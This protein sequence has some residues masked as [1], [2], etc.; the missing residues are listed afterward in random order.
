M[1]QPP[2]EA[3]LIERHINMTKYPNY[4]YFIR[5]RSGVRGGFIYAVPTI[6]NSVLF[7][8]GDIFHY[9][10]M[11]CGWVTQNLGY[12]GGIYFQYKK[13]FSCIFLKFGKKKQ[14]S[15]ES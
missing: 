1:E 6:I 5:L 13:R 14:N 2:R 7:V 11:H 3:P 8:Y 9:K 15:C 4:G 10:R 12:S